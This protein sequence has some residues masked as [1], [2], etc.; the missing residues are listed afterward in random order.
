MQILSLE[1][2]PIPALPPALSLAARGVHLLVDLDLAREHDAV[3][4][5]L[6]HGEELGHPPGGG[7]AAPPVL[8][9]Y[10]L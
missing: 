10:R 5:A 8:P 7:G 1:Y 3:L 4:N 6:Q 2:A 9:G